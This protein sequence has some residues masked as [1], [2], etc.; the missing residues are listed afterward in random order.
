M[1]FDGRPFFYFWPNG[2]IF[3]T[4]V[5]STN[6]N[7]I[8]MPR[9]CLQIE[10]FKKYGQLHSLSKIVFINDHLPRSVISALEFFKSSPCF[11]SWYV[12]TVVGSISLC[13]V[14]E[15]RNRI[16]VRR[17]QYL[18]VFHSLFDHCDRFNHS[19]KVERC[20]VWDLGQFGNLTWCYVNRTDNVSSYMVLILV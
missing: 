3:A 17:L 8:C 18:Y 20:G 7:R 16:I 13:E 4:A 9:S 2:T 14:G 15:F 5:G 10:C 1:A 12:D 6:F 11:D 19:C